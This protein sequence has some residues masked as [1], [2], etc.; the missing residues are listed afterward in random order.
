[1]RIFHNPKDRKGLEENERKAAVSVKKTNYERMESKS[2]GSADA[3][4]EQGEQA[5]EGET[6]AK[7]AWKKKDSASV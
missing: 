7:K 4:K 3:E 6:T 2:T 5:Q 1:M